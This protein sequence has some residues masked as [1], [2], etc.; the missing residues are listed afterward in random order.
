MPITNNSSYRPTI[1][2]FIA[3]WSQVDAELPVPIVTY[4]EA[5]L[6]QSLAQFTDLSTT[7]DT[8]A[9]EV[10]DALTTMALARGDIDLKKAQLLAWLIEFTGLMDAYWVGTA[11]MKARP[12]GP[13][14]TLGEEKFINPM[15]DAA[16]LWTKLNGAPAPGGVTLPLALSDGTT[17]AQF[18]TALAALQ[19]V[20]AQERIAAQD[21][22]LARAFREESKRSAYLTIKAYRLAVAARCAQFPVLVETLPALT[23]APGHTPDPVQASAVFQAPDLAKVV[24]EASEEAELDHYELRGNPGDAYHDD[25]AVTIDTHLPGDPREFLTGFSLTQPGAHVALK[26]YVVLKTGNEAGSAPMVVQRPA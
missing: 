15:R 6:A 22:V 7:L 16:S 11:Y 20:Y 24:Y 26:V 25:D 19:V 1:N 14:I 4:N 3:H 18:A 12:R 17:Q 13:S 10:I 23:P 9:T 5:K 21:L 8:Q 2:E